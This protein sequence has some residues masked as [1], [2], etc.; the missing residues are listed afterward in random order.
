MATKKILTETPP[1]LGKVYKILRNVDDHPLVRTPLKGPLTIGF[2]EGTWNIHFDL[3]LEGMTVH[4]LVISRYKKL[5]TAVFHFH[6]RMHKVE[7]FLR[8]KNAGKRG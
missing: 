4:A 8:E 1:I 3:Y 7:A 5:E 6:R 2:A